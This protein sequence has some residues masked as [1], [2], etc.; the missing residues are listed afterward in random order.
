MIVSVHVVSHFFDQVVVLRDDPSVKLRSLIV[1][2][3]DRSRIYS[4]L[5]RIKCEEVVYVLQCSE[6]L[7]DYFDQSVFIEF[8]R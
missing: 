6:E 3:L 5:V 4:V 8:R 1:R 2:D 7:A